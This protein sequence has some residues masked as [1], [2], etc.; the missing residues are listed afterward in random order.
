MKD[1]RA[2]IIAI[3][4]IAAVLGSYWLLESRAQFDG[5]DS[6]RSENVASLFVHHSLNSPLERFRLHVGRFPTT[7]E[8]LAALVL[9]PKDIE[10][11]WRGPYLDR[12]PLDPWRHAYQ[13][14]SPGTHSEIGY[15]LWSLGADGFASA[16]DL[17]NWKR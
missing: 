12:V 1:P 11:R 5:G 16:D 10:I 13:Y 14:R 8:G 9:A 15:D 7:E 4:M 2:G 17:G 6:L 3:S